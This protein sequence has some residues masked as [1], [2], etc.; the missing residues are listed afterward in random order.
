MKTAVS[1]LLVY[2]IF[3]ICFV[4]KPNDVFRCYPEFSNNEHLNEVRTR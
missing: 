2:V 3:G 4:N 1:V